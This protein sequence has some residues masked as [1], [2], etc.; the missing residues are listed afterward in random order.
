[1]NILLCPLSDGGYLYPAIA[2]GRELRR[3]G[4]RVGVLG[5]S[6]AAPVAA[7]ASL[8]FAAAEAFGGRRAFSATWWG[9]TG[10]A[11]YRA[12]VRAARR[13]GPTCWSPRCSATERCSPPRHWTF[14][15]R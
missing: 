7:G 14:R 6:T 11:Q 1:M 8:P 2:A 5:R 12:T 4:H 10:L 9:A 15:R 13:P 3:R